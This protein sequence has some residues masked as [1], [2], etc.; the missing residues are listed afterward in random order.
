MN[1]YSFKISPFGG[2]IFI[3]LSTFAV[4][5]KRRFLKKKHSCGFIYFKTV[6]YIH[7]LNT[8]HFH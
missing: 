2:D 4:G 8:Y 6:L 1:L 7:I 3:P 5:N